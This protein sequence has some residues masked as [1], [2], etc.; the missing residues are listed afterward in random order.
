TAIR[1]TVATFIEY[2][3]SVLILCPEHDA[4]CGYTALKKSAAL[5]NENNVKLAE[6]PAVGH[7]VFTEDP[8]TR[9][10]AMSVILPWLDEVLR[11]R[12]APE[13]APRSG[14]APHELKIAGASKSGRGLALVEGEKPGATK[15]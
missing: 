6:L 14:D 2:H 11:V 3:G 13:A 5:H 4:V 10:A 15:L 12:Q 7:A 9:T 1:R 8:V